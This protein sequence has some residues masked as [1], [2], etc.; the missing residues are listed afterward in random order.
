MGNFSRTT[1]DPA[2]AYSAVRLQQGVPLVD[3][4]W[5]E[6]QD[7][8][9][10]ELYDALLTVAPNA[11]QASVVL[12]GAGNNDLQLSPGVVVV[13][14]RPVR[15]ASPIRYTT[16]RY[17]NGATAAAD[18]VPAAAPL[19]TPGTARTDIVFLDV[20]E[21]EVGRAEDPNIVNAAIGIETSVRLRREIVLRVAEGG[22]IPALPAGHVTLFIATLNRAAGQAAITQAMIDDIAP[23]GQVPAI[24]DMA[25]APFVFP[26]SSGSFGPQTPWL[27]QFVPGV[28]Q[29]ILFRPANATASGI[30]PVSFPHLARI[31]S[32]RVRGVAGSGSGVV[33]CGMSRIRL[34]TGVSSTIVSDTVATPGAFDR[35]LVVPPTGVGLVDNLTFSYSISFSS[36]QSTDSAEVHGVTIRYI[37]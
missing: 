2:K 19:T 15:I 33:I 17:A 7:I 27:H 9:R 21:R 3:A 16:Q 13:G 28:G 25:V 5:N 6:L 22:A 12:V 32:M 36:G 31:R 24:V 1:F 30:A 20:F 4:D 37:D 35:T 14:G 23:R 18:G 10:N 11:L 26:V 34:D 29:T 8:T